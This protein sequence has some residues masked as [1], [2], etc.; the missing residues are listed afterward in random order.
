M[1]GESIFPEAEDDGCEPFRQIAKRLGCDEY[2]VSD[3]FDGLGSPAWE[4]PT[5]LAKVKKTTHA[6]NEAARQA[7]NLLRAMRNLSQ[8]TRDSLIVAGAPTLHQI[9][10]LRDTLSS[11]ELNLKA[12]A[13]RRNRSGGRNPAAYIVSEGM[14][15]VFRRLRKTITFGNHPDGGPSTEF[16][17]EVQFALGAFG[18]KADWRRPTEDAYDKQGRIRTRMVACQ[19]AKH[20]KGLLPLAPSFPDLSGI[21]I[22]TER[23]GQGLTFVVSL[24][25]WQQVPP[26]RIRNKNVTSGREVAEYAAQWAASVRAAKG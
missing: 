12:W 16:G 15:R 17:R 20:R 19:M 24:V 1:T 25:D 22:Q 7:G 21:D 9:E 8:E 10:F 23:D 13:E 2:L 26:L 4:V 14:R 11:D 18:V 3:A 5:H 6:L